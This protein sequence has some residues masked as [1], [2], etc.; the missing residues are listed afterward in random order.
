[1]R[2]NVDDPMVR[3]Y[4]W[5]R[6]YRDAVLELD[7]AEMRTKITRAFAQLER[8]SREVMFTH[9][10]DLT[11]RQAIIDAVNGLRTIERFE[12]NGLSETGSSQ[13]QVAI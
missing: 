10:A 7:P 6:A 3:V 5:E 8:R 2:Q 9:E 4:C 13:L 12:L 1:M 11:E